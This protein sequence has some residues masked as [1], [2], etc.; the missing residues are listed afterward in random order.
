MTRDVKTAVVTFDKKSLFL[1]ESDK[2]VLDEIE[3]VIVSRTSR[4]AVEIAKFVLPRATPGLI[5]ITIGYI[6]HSEFRVVAQRD[7][8]E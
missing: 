7:N 4:Q 1:M 6:E 5:A 3:Y 8:R 2:E